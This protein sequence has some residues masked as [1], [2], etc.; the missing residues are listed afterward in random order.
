VTLDQTFIDIVVIEVF[1][2]VGTSL[3][4]RDAMP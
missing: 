1:G 4:A 3:L 2:V